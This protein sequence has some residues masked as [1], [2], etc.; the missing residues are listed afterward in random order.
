[1]MTF[2]RIF[3]YELLLLVTFL[4]SVPQIQA[5]C[6]GPYLGYDLAIAACSKVRIGSGLCGN[7]QGKV[8]ICGVNLNLVSLYGNCTADNNCF[9]P[10]HIG[11]CPS[12]EIAD[13][14]TGICK[15]VEDNPAPAKNFGSCQTAGKL[16]DDVNFSSQ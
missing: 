2:R 9:L 10:Y 3:K 7:S 13:P 8:S 12:G 15:A 6:F 5:A 16:R 1:M 14:E 11:S 4:F